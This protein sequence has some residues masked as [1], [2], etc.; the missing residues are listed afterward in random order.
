MG[1]ITHSYT[2]HNQ[3]NWGITIKALLKI[4]FKLHHGGGLTGCNH[5]DHDMYGS[6]YNLVRFLLPEIHRV[7]GP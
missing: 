2:S 3:S 1:L 7:G 5:S 4:D 6:N